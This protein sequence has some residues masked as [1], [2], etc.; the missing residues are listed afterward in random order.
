MRRQKPRQ[1][2]SLQRQKRRNKFDK[3]VLMKKEIEEYVMDGLKKIDATLDRIG[4]GLHE[5]DGE[6]EKM[7]VERNEFNLQMSYLKKCDIGRPLDMD[8]HSFEMT[9]Q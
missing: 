7:K 5:I 3:M 1:Q 4:E 9:Y 6:I 8:R 2:Q